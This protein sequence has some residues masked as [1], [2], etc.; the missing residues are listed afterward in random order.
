MAL[1]AYARLQ[2]RTRALREGFQLHLPK[3]V[4]PDELVA[5]V[6]NLGG[7]LSLR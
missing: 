7:R 6:A 3:P 2:D 1:T 4:E 5:A